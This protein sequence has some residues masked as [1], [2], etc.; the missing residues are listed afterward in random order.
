M[1]GGAK[2]GASFH[3]RC[4]WTLDGIDIEAVFNTIY[5]IYKYRNI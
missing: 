1:G 5:K 3:A 4:A 2:R